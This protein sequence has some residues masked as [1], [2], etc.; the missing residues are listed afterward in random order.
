MWL[1]FKHWFGFHDFE[2][3]EDEGRYAGVLICTVCRML[4]QPE[5]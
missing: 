5:R 4:I 3:F 2:T 1:R